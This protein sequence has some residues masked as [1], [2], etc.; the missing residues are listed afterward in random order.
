MTLGGLLL[1]IE[2]VLMQGGA[3]LPG[4]PETVATLTARGLPVR[5]L[6]NTTTRP[7]REIAA[8]LADA[9]FEASQAQV[10]SPA[11]AAARL[12][13]RQGLKRVHLATLPGLAEEFEGF[14]LVDD[15]A[16]AVVVGDLHTGFSW[17][18]LN[19]LFELLVD[20]ALLIALHKNRYCRR[21]ETIGLDLGPFV[22]AL[23]Y[24]TGAQATVVGKPARSFFE[25]GI[26]SLGLAPTEILMVGD[27][28]DADIAGAL[29]VGL[30]ALQVRTGKYRAS[31]EEPS[32]PQPTAR[33]DSIAELPGCRLGV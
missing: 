10:L 4:G 20:G 23:E 7:R 31:D 29:D 1:D 15:K 25:D 28:I 19:R 2:G 30:Y 9:R 16:N 5:Y 33:L 11:S 8:A 13:H 14:D 6:T 18:R 32:H 3:A 21:G 17:A 22:A 26:A 27:D 12:L 24:A